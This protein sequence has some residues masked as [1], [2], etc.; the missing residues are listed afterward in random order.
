MLTIDQLDERLWSLRELAERLNVKYQT[1]RSWYYN[2]L[3][4]GIKLGGEIKGVVRIPESEVNRFLSR[5]QTDAKT[6][7]LPPGILAELEQKP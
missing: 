3:I 5:N 2:G 7:E 1:V 6:L 4:Q